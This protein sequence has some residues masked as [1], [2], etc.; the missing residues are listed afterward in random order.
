MLLRDTPAAI[1][2]LREEADPGTVVG[3]SGP[4]GR[5]SRV[6][7]AEREAR[8]ALEAGG[9]DGRRVLRYGED[10]GSFF[11]PH[12]LSEAERAV[13]HVLGELLDYDR[14]HRSDLVNSLR[15]FLDHNRSWKDAAA[16]LQ[17]HKQTL[18]YRM[19]RVEQLT[20]RH[21]DETGDVAELWFALRAAN[22]A[23]PPSSSG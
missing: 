1:A 12:G 3:L 15:V 5:P 19:R 14:E 2:V 22:V 23:R 6:A 16:A 7:D 9:E 21:L 17:V 18:V 11:L 8:W 13:A 20:G 10:V 4:L